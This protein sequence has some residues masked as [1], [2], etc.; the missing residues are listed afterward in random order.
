MIGGPKPEARKSNEGPTIWH[1]NC[2]ACRC[3]S[4][5]FTLFADGSI[6]CASCHH[7]VPQLEVH[8]VPNIR[9]KL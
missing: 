1:C 3:N 7:K 4:S 5:S 8:I 9:R 6:E 2:A